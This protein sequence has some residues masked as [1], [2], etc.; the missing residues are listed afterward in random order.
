MRLYAMNASLEGNCRGSSMTNP[1]SETA[2][3]P[4]T[5]IAAEQYEPE[6]QRLVQD[7]LAYHFLPS[8]VQRVVRLTRWRPMRKLLIAL[9]EKT[10]YGIWGSMLCR[11]RYIDDL[12]SQ[13]LGSV[14]AL[15]TLHTD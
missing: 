3:G 15:V 2:V 4:M 10:A 6:G 11:K 1:A 5:I 7:D 14:D 9:T 13:S 8:G 12:I